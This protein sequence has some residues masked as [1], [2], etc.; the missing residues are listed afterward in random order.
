MKRF[1]LTNGKFAL[2]PN[3]WFTKLSRWRW[4]AL[5]YGR[6]W[7]AVRF[8]GKRKIYMHRVIAGAVRG[9]LVDHQDGCGLHNWPSNLRFAS[10]SQNHANQEKARGKLNRL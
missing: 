6:H 7:Y 2:V 1:R 9:Q 8:S 4:H 5:P 10:H 3:R